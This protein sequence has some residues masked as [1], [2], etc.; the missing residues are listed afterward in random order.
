MYR[1]QWI[2]SIEHPNKTSP[3]EQKTHQHRRHLSFSKKKRKK[4]KEKKRRH[5]QRNSQALWRGQ[6]VSTSYPS[7]QL[8]LSKYRTEYALV[9]LHLHRQRLVN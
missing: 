1:I 9:L 6:P 3:K 4:G 5:T 7:T 2:L 8:S